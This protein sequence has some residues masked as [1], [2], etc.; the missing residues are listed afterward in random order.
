MKYL[1][2]IILITANSLVMAQKPTMQVWT[3]AWHSADAESFKNVYA[4]NA[5]IFPPNKPTVQGNEKILEFMKGGLGKVD[6][7]FEKQNLI[8]SENLAFEFGVFKDIE[9]ASPK[10]L[11]EGKY[12]VTWIL[13][14]SVWKV[15]CHTWSMP[16][17]F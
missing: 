5:L 1:L 9:L 17:K 3:D 8:I 2:F 15:Q 11:G 14:N 7:V 12:S 4:K 6:V 10:V 13:E 16:V